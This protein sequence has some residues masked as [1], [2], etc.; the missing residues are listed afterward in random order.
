MRNCFEV[1]TL[2]PLR[3]HQALGEQIRT[4]GGKV[5]FVSTGMGSID[6]NGSGGIYAYRVSKAGVNMLAKGMSCDLKKKD[7]SVISISP[8]LIVTDFGAG[9]DAMKMMNG[10]PVDECGQKMLQI[11]SEMSMENTGTFVVACPGKGDGP[12]P[13][14]W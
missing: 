13:M 2:G 10:K 5:V 14:P 11:V 7:I 6:D 4:P 1:N 3:V 12:K 9:A 8:G